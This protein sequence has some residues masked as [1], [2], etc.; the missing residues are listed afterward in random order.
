MEEEF[1]VFSHIINRIDDND[2]TF[3][4]L[5]S[6]SDTQL[7]TISVSGISV[8]N[9][10]SVGSPVVVV[11]FIDGAGDIANFNRLDTNG[12]Y[13]LYFGR[14]SLNSRRLPLRISKV[15]FSNGVAGQSR[16]YGFQ[17]FFVMANWQEFLHKTYN[18]GW[19][20][21]KYSSIISQIATESGFKSVEVSDTPRQL[22][23][24]TQPYWTNLALVND[25]RKKAL[26]NEGAGHFEFGITLDNDFFFMNQD[27]MIKR[28][29]ERSNVNN[30]GKVPILRMGGYEKKESSRTKEKEDNDEVPANFVQIQS[31]ERFMDS[32]VQGAGGVES[33]YYDF[34]NRQFVRTVHKF[35]ESPSKTL[36]DWSLVHPDN[37]LATLK[38][39]GGRNPE[40]KN[41]ASNR[42]S[43]VM[44]GLNPMQLTTEGATNYEIGGIV[45]LI[46]PNPPNAGLDSP[47]N[48]MYSGF[49]FIAEV[50]HLFSFKRNTYITK[51]SISR[52][53]VDGKDVPSLVPSAGGKVNI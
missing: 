18:R 14:D 35:S 17:V 7:R 44:F 38:W 20:N 29:V 31:N 15:S 10:L 16:S 40:T 53:G 49:Y 36:S 22:E 1:V 23:S 5:T 33:Q 28:A 45:E 26:T 25:I 39:Y 13:Y 4:A 2:N 19:R 51:L 50:E 8:K 46:I 24:V 9:G 47:Y 42:V 3:I 43:E 30:G 34:V 32:V 21:I 12:N 6:D 11:N 27:D 48:E 41:Q 37:E 52:H